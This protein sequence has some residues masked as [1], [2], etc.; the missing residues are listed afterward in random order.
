MGIYSKELGLFITSQKHFIQHKNI[1]H[2]T[3]QFHAQLGLV[4]GMGT[5]KEQSSVA[6][7]C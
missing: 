7:E 3:V 1:F 2:I 6:E 5:L 4:L